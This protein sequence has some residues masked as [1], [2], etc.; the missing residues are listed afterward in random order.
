[1]RTQKT[2]SLGYRTGTPLHSA[3][4]GYTLIELLLV[5]ALLA[6][7]L[8]LA[9]PNYQR[10]QAS[11]QLQS[12]AH[13]IA[14]QIRQTRLIALKENCSIRILCSTGSDGLQRL[15]RYRGVFV[16]KP[17]YTICSDVTVSRLDFTFLANGNINLGGSITLC[18]RLGEALQIV[19]Q[20]VTGRVVI[21]ENAFST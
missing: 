14:A 2:F 16:I 7:L 8:V 6:M 12:T 17:T 15:A 4:L 13:E 5:L 1:M 3:K 11:L 21:R 19:I 10:M 9:L 20:P 18:N